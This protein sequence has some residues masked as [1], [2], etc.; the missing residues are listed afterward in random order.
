MA[1]IATW[2]FTRGLHWDSSIDFMPTSDTVQKFHILYMRVRILSCQWQK[3]E[4]Y[5]YIPHQIKLPIRL[6]QEF[7]DSLAI[8]FP[9]KNKHP[10]IKVM[11]FMIYSFQVRTLWI[12]FRYGKWPKNDDDIPFGPFKNHDFIPFSIIFICS[13]HHKNDDL[14]FIENGDLTWKNPG[15][16]SRVQTARPA[17]SAMTSRFPQIIPRNVIPLAQ[18]TVDG[19]NPASPKGWFFNP[20]MGSTTYW[21]RISQPSTVYTIIVP[22]SPYCWLNTHEVSEIAAS[23]PWNTHDRSQ[24]IPLFF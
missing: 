24:Y 17:I 20:K 15:Y 6:L 19:R 4:L 12:P 5:I 8:P 1:S 22:I 3:I 9:K 10:L 7:R 18:C 21:C 13:Y 23:P 14:P 2:K 11:V 16:P